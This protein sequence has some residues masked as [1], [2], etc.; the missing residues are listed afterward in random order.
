MTSKNRNTDNRSTG[1]AQTREEIV[2]SGMKLF[3]K[4]LG[5]IPTQAALEHTPADHLLEEIK[6]AQDLEILEG[7]HA[8]V[9]VVQENTNKATAPTLP[10]SKRDFYININKLKIH[11]WNARVHRPQS[12]VQELAFLLLKHGQ[13]SPVI[14]TEDPKEPDTFYILDGE[15]RYQSA[16]HLDW[17]EL[18][19]L[20]VDIDPSKSLKFYIRSLQQTNS[21]QP[22]SIIDQA[23]R[24][25]ELI[26]KKLATLDEIAN[27]VEKTK[28]TVSKML[29]YGRFKPAVREF[30]SEH[31]DKFPYTLVQDLSR[32]IT[33]DKSEDEILK[34]CDAIVEENISRRGLEDLIKRLSPKDSGK[35][36]YKRKQAQIHIP[37]KHGNTPIGGFRTFDNG[38]M[39]FKL[40]PE[41]EM[42]E[43]L[44]AQ[45]SS[46]LEILAEAACKNN[47]A[48]MK[49]AIVNKLNEFK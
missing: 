14:V 21:T 29:V 28:S 7:T 35:R 10:S 18:W 37:I 24:W 41:A 9:V 44:L 1:V 30:M 49:L 26:D 36:S 19:V 48:E 31:L 34:I 33:D 20:P 38:G 42:D 8:P 40:Q 32:I 25:Q 12:R 22:I 15:T 13:E 47:S 11:E 2:G 45:L 39:E 46:C 23:I 16:K 27:E 43:N 17:K 4:S 5:A 3:P 6:A